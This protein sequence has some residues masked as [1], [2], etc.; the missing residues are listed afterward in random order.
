MHRIPP[1]YCELSTQI[2]ILLETIFEWT[3]RG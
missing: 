3:D 1:L 2:R